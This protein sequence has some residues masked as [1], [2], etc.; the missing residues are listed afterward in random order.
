MHK[1]IVVTLFY[2]LSSALE[3]FRKIILGAAIVLICLAGYRFYNQHLDLSAASLIPDSSPELVRISEFLDINP[4]SRVTLVE[5]RSEGTDDAEIM[6]G[7]AKELESALSEYIE[8]SR[9]NGLPKPDK[10]V[11]M[12][13]YLFDAEAEA[14]IKARSTPDAVAAS[15]KGVREAMLGMYGFAPKDFLRADPLGWLSLIGEKANPELFQGSSFDPSNLSSYPV[16]EDGKYVLLILRPK[17]DLYDVDHARDIM[18][19]IENKFEEM[20]SP[21]DGRIQATVVGGPRYTAEN[22][23]TIERDLK[24]TLS[25]SLACLALIYIF[26]VRSLGAIWLLLT[27]V[28]AVIFSGSALSF[29]WP[30]TAGL[31]L[32]FGAAVLGIAEDFAVLMHFALRR[33][34][35]AMSRPAIIA[36]VARP[37]L[38]SASLCMASFCV[39][40][41]SGLPALRQLGFFAAGSLLAGVIIATLILPYCPWI[42]KPK[43]KSLERSE[44]AVAL[45]PKPGAVLLMLVLLVGVSYWGFKNVPFNSSVQKLGMNTEQIQAEIAE[46]RSHWQ[47]GP[48]PYFWLNS[49]ANQDEALAKASVLVKSLRENGIIAFSLADML[50]PA[51]IQRDNLARWGTFVRENGASI[52]NSLLK[53]A[54]TNGFK[55]SAFRSFG[56]WLDNQ[57]LKSISGQLVYTPSALRVLIEEAGLGD[58]FW[59]MSSERNGENFVFTYSNQALDETLLPADIQENTLLFSISEL[60]EGLTGA[61][62]REIWLLPIAGVVCLILLT[63]CFRR[64]IL[65]VLACLPPLFGISSIVLWQYFSGNDLTLAGVAALTLVIGLGAD[66]G[67]VMLHELSSR[68]SFGAFR[69]ILVSG[70]TTLSG[71]GVLILAKHPVLRELGGITFFGLGA[72]MIA[73]LLIVPFLCR[74]SDKPNVQK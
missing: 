4:S 26:T 61:F 1:S 56:D 35:G 63:L 33:N 51:D 29:V 32:A 2:R 73:V 8:E 12:L 65:V 23:V 9:S 14:A 28:V 15:V 48:E 39:L 44:E 22:A 43:I 24:V 55:K 68:M 53:A 74:R 57:R 59:W 3:P 41:F 16:S 70:L 64:P 66:Y 6:R 25:L 58:M 11:A 67:I 60:T 50:P 47:S 45:N 46:L 34:Q 42:D 36:S 19:T 17:Y 62:D 30:A 69:S 20:L 72:E 18:M 7:M 38:F 21:Y 5:F 31:A 52:E 40:L 13:P 10:L 71:L 27:P 37:M 54:E 49:G